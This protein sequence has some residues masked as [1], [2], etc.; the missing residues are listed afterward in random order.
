MID[1]ALLA[2]D[3]K[4]QKTVQVLKRE[5]ETIRSG[6]ATSAL[7]DQIMVEAY[8]TS[9]PL[10]QLASIS[11]PEARL[12]LIQPW[13]RSIVGNVQKA[14]QKS[15]LGLNPMSDGE[16]LRLVI[17]PPTEERRKE[18]VKVVHKRVEDAKIAV[19]NVRRDALEELRKLEKDKKVS[20]DENV[21][22]TDKLQKLTDR[23]IAE[24]SKVGA[25]KESEIME[26]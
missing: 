10:S 22:A 11:V 21:R 23:F 20:R 24:V 17:P 1:D 3:N 7:V 16:V 12:L 5:M 14:I 9:T 4:M 13:D 8:G 19:R 6:R 2:A 15:D 18:L 25:D 26:V